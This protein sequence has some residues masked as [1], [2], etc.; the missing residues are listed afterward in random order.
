MLLIGTIYKNNHNNFFYFNVIN[1]QSTGGEI[2]YKLVQNKSIWLS[3]VS[4]N[5]PKL[6]N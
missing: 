6:V 3:A 1:A 4:I 5:N 2:V